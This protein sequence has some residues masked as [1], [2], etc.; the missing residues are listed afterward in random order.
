MGPRAKKA[1][2]VVALAGAVTVASASEACRSATQ[3]E[4]DV[5]YN[6]PCKDLDSVAFIVGTDPYVAESR[7]ANNVFTTTTRDCTQVSPTLARVGTLVLT[8]NADTNHTALVV[9]AGFGIPVEQC[10]A[11]DGY[12]GCI[13]A[14]RSFVF[15]PHTSLTLGVSLDADCL[16][17][18]CS[19]VSTCSHKQCID[20]NVECS[21]D[22]CKKVGETDDGGVATVD[23]PT[24]SDAYVQMLDGTKPPTDAPVDSPGDGPVDA[25]A[26]QLPKI[27]LTCVVGASM[28]KTC[29]PGDHC[30]SGSS[31][32]SD[33]G[34]GGDGGQTQQYDCRTG[35]TV[36]MGHPD[37]QCTSAKNCPLGS[38]C[39]LMAF[40][41]S[42][43]VCMLTCGGAMLPDSALTTEQLCEDDCECLNGGRCGMDFTI[44]TNVPQPVRKCY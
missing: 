23:A 24:S 13:I 30:C 22:G 37:V 1:S 6:G 7:I 19:A 25:G 44:G 26:C 17:V 29:N 9:L 38:V 27:P 28:K 20:S 21:A 15:V 18:P 5:T 14:R 41:G 40:P 36:D 42:P 39:C 16:N 4:L 12:F 43:A 32:V 35:C 31:G 8:P 3:M 2:I 11:S 33:G 34:D 10:K